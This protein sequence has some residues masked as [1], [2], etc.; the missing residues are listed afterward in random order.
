VPAKY[1]L[2]ALALVFLVASVMRVARDGGKLRPQS[3][4]WLLIA[5]IF[6]AVSAWLW[7]AV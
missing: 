2:A 5:A 7:Y 4:T 3:R 6:G 1:I